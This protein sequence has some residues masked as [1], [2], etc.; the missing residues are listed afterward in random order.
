[1]A[2]HNSRAHVTM[3]SYIIATEY[4]MSYF[5]IHSI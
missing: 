1:V 5:S 4:V 2:V 3:R